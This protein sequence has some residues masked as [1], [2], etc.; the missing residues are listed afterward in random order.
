LVDESF[1]GGE[2]RRGV[3]DGLCAGCVVVESFGVF[4]FVAA[5]TQPAELAEAW[6]ELG[7][8]RLLDGVVAPPWSSGVAPGRRAVQ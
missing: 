8:R 5:S 3:L 4:Q 1:G 6:A 2:D 7:P